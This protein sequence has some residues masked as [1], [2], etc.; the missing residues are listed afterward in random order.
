[1]NKYNMYRFFSLFDDSSSHMFLVGAQIR[2]ASKFRHVHPLRVRHT[3]TYVMTLP[4]SGNTRHCFGTQLLLR[5]LIIFCSFSTLAFNFLLSTRFN[6]FFPALPS[7]SLRTFLSA[8]DI[9]HIGI[10]LYEIAYSSFS[11]H[12]FSS[13]FFF[14]AAISQ[15]GGKKSRSRR[16]PI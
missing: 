14:L 4:L 12:K 2:S 10:S 9:L 5:Q 16:T 6:L 3:K 7:L 15:R 13:F 8:T 11:D 1:M